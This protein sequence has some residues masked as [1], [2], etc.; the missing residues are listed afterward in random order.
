MNKKE[1][2]GK[3]HHVRQITPECDYPLYKTGTPAAVLLP[4]IERENQLTMLFTLRAKNLKHHPGQVSFPGGKQESSDRNLLATALRE[5]RE[6][7]GLPEDCVEIIGNLPP[8]RTVSRFEVLPFI[9]FITPPINL[10][11]DKNE[12]D[13]VFEVPLAHLLDQKNHLIHWVM[14]EGQRYPVYFI[15]WQLNNIWGATAAFIRTLSNH[16]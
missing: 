2:L 11:L 7:I 6:E 8:Y 13:S 14:R 5:T 1:F 3:F 15:P 12:V 10:T 16:V 4:I 9:G